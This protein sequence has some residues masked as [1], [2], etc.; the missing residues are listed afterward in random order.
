MLVDCL[1]HL[2]TSHCF[3]HWIQFKAGM[4]CSF[5]GFSPHAMAFL[6]QRLKCMLHHFSPVKLHAANHNSRVKLRRN[7][8]RELDDETT[9]KLKILQR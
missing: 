8:M 9:K 3:F 4:F 5:C 1:F 2:N 6:T 7:K